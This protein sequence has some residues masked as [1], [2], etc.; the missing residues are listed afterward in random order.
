MRQVGGCP[1]QVPAAQRAM[2]VAVHPRC[3]RLTDALQPQYAADMAETGT[4]RVAIETGVVFGS[5]AGRELRC[6]IYTP[7]AGQGERYWRTT[8]IF[9]TDSKKYEWLTHIVAV[10]V[11]FTVPQRVSYRIF[12]IV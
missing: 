1:T 6:D 4:G 2:R 9:E 3:H 12:Q 11:S 10:G 5:A 7:P 8:P